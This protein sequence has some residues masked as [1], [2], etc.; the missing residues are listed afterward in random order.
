MKPPEGLYKMPEAGPAKQVF[1][2]EPEQLGLG[3]LILNIHESPVLKGGLHDSMSFAVATPNIHEGE[4]PE[5]T[6]LRVAGEYQKLQLTDHYADSPQQASWV[7]FRNNWTQPIKRDEIIAPEG[8]RTP[9]DLETHIGEI[10]IDNMRSIPEVTPIHIALPNKHMGSG[11]R[12]AEPKWGWDDAFNQVGHR[13]LGNAEEVRNTVENAAAMIDQRGVFSNS[14]LLVI[15]R[16][17]PELFGLMVDQLASV[18]GPQVRKEFL[19]SMLKNWSTWTA[20]RQELADVHGEDTGMNGLSMRLPNGLFLEGVGNTGDTPRPEMYKE[21]LEMAH[22]RAKDLH[23]TGAAYDAE[24]RTFYNS[25]RGGALLGNDFHGGL[26]KDGKSL[27][28]IDTVGRMPVHINALLANDELIIAETFEAMGELEMAKYFY[29]Q[30]NGRLETIDTYLYNPKTKT[31][32]DRYLDG[33]W[34]EPDANMAY[35]LYTGFAPNERVNGVVDALEDYVKPGGILTTLNEAP[36]SW[37]GDTD[38]A[39]TAYP[40][41]RGLARAG[42]GLG[43]EEGERALDLATKGWEAFLGGTLLSF[44]ATGQVNERV[45]ALDPGNPS[46]INHTGEYGNIDDFPT[47]GL[48]YQALKRSHPMDRSGGAVPFRYHMRR[49]HYG[50]AA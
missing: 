13:A 49:R 44:Q 20:G 15:E 50:L 1:V 22:E 12:F 2:P 27:K 39:M 47:R 9:R 8:H 11:G 10:I 40:V 48:V 41:I 17:H 45:N 46:A 29:D 36:F 3:Q 43:G 35:M 30:V 23:L 31:Y 5:R 42:H 19:D 4:T 18:E 32:Q 28:T 6:W 33:R 24:V 26:C 25:V 38:W 34:A 7:F 14:G 21:D 37:G 16:P